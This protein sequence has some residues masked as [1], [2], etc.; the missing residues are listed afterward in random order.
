[1][2]GQRHH[3]T[4]VGVPR[5]PRFMEGR[6][7]GHAPP[8][9]TPPTAALRACEEIHRSPFETPI[10]WAPQDERRMN[11]LVI[12]QALRVRRVV[13]GGPEVAPPWGPPTLF[14]T[15]LSG[16]RPSACASPGLVWC[17]CPAIGWRLGRSVVYWG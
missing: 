2:A 6:P 16:G 12:S 17:R 9:D 13:S 1:M 15:L 4:T 8:F 5:G 11:R 7:M 14:R 10:P 3:T